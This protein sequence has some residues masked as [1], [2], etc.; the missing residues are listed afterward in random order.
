MRAVT[1]PS[2]G[3]LDLAEKPVPRPADDQVLVKVAAAG[4]NR[5]DLW[6]LAGGYAAPADAPQDIPGL[7]FAGTVEAVGPAVKR[8]KVGDR[9]Y[10]LVGGGAQ[11]EFVAV[12]EGHCAIVP[13]RLD[14]V[15][16]GAVPEAFITA[17]DA[18]TTSGGLRDGQSILIHAVGSGV[19]TAALQIG[20]AKGCT[21]VGTA[22][23]P[24]KLARA[25]QLGLDQAI[26]IPREVNAAQLTDLMRP[27]A[28][29][30]NA[31]LDLVGGDYLAADV[32]AAAPRGVI[33]MLSTIGG[34]LAQVNLRTFMNK[35]LTLRGT[36]LRH[37]PKPEKEE[38][39]Q[40]FAR[41]LGPLFA[42]GALRP[43]LET[44]VSLDEV[45][46]AYELLR[47]DKTFGKVVLKIV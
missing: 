41:D 28:G 4:L 36:T 33:V 35:R 32:E 12:A 7:E 25:R 5:G 21:V 18:L 13:D 2:K 19:G 11:A 9:V 20:K 1:I 37:R 38:A 46:D 22:R 8:L 40:A 15:T 29:A 39:V 26:E 47:S 3:R 23:S 31:V 14:L 10:G 44:V 34:D 17:H 16:A 42:S 24:E 30:M 6:Q 43:V 27:V 45:R